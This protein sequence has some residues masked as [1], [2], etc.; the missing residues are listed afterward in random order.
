MLSCCAY[1]HASLM[2]LNSHSGRL[3]LWVCR[4]WGA[5]TERRQVGLQSSLCLLKLALAF[6]KPLNISVPQFTCGGTCFSV[7]ERMK[8]YR[9]LALVMIMMI[10]CWR[11]RR[12]KGEG[13]NH[14]ERRTRRGNSQRRKS[15]GGAR[16]PDPGD[17]STADQE[18][19]MWWIWVLSPCCFPL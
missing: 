12:G 7:T 2:P 19:Q 1:S 11:R 8:C 5:F 9:V 10:R 14:L 6:G 15:Q 17:L 18:N 3:G 4:V 13:K 16:T